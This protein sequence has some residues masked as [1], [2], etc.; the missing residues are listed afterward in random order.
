MK[1]GAILPHMR[2]FGGV[3][4]FLEIGNTMVDR[5]IDYTIHARKEKICDWFDFRGRVEDCSSIKADYIIA[6]YPPDFS[7]LPRVKGKIYIYVLAGGEYIPMYKQVYGKYPF[8]LNNR[9]FLEWFPGS[10]LVEGA[11]NVYRFSPG[12][13]WRWSRK[14]TRIIFFDKA[15]KGSEHIKQS[16]K[17]IK[18]IEL[19][20][21]KGL[22]DEQLV[23]AYR[24][25]DFFV[26]WEQRPGWSNTAAEALACGLTV[27]TSGRNCEPFIDKVI[28]TPDLRRFFLNP[29]NRKMRVQ[30]SMDMFSWEKTVDQLLEIFKEPYPVKTVKKVHHNHKHDHRHKK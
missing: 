21:L 22:N 6:S 15:T 17:G 20:G 9:V 27:V 10:Y 5:G 18:G 11:V 4:R 8:I 29:E 3:R 2:Q 28:I 25:G 24:S 12:R 30:E 7:V 23:A 19:F 1:I 26:S 14:K 13:S 16:L